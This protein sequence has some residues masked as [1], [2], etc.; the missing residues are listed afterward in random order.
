MISESP[1]GSFFLC[2]KESHTCTAEW[3]PYDLVLKDLRSLSACLPLSLFLSS[4]VP[5]DLVS[6]GVSMVYT[7]TNFLIKC[8]FNPALGV[9]FST[10]FAI[11]FGIGISWE[12]SRSLSFCSFL[13]NSFLNPSPHRH[14]QFKHSGGSKL[15]LHPVSWL[16]RAT[17]HKTLGHSSAASFP[18]LQPSPLVCCAVTRSSLVLGVTTMAIFCSQLL[19]SLRRWKLSP[20]LSTFLSEP[21]P[22]LPITISSRRSWHFLAHTSRLPVT[23]F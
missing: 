23:W 10:S 2:L 14:L 7:H 22:E 15:P 20:Q 5:A 19:C 17:C 3:P 18:T 8:L 16:T 11:F 9:L 21:S 6:T 1:L 12:S 4:S 13:L